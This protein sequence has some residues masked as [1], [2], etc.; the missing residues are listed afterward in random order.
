MDK[1]TVLT[2]LRYD[3]VLALLALVLFFWEDTAAPAFVAVC[4][5]MAV[6]FLVFAFGMRLLT[7]GADD[8]L[9][10]RRAALALG[11]Y[12]LVHALAIGLKC[13]L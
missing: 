8:A 11:A 12:A 7:R 9:P 6:C 13:I 1:N 5:T 4:I 3:L 10:K 2:I